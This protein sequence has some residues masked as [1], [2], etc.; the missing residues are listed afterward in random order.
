M[1]LNKTE[2]SLS[3]THRLVLIIMKFWGGKERT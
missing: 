1:D 2:G 3:S